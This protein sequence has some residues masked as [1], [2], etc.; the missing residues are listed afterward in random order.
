MSIWSLQDGLDRAANAAEEATRKV[1]E[2]DA[3][4]QV[5][6]RRPRVA[7]MHQYFSPCLPTPCIIA[8]P[9]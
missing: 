9:A 7:S 5:R 2:R 1:E 8:L 4:L 3:K 6:H